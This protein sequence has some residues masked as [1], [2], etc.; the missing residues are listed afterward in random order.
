S[1][2]TTW[3]VDPQFAGASLRVTATGQT[4][5]A[6]AT[7][8]FTDSNVK[9]GMTTTGD[10]NDS[11]TVNWTTYSPSGSIDSGKSGTTALSVGGNANL[12]G[13]PPGSRL[14]ITAPSFSKEGKQF[15]YWI[16]N[17]GSSQTV[18]NKP[19]LIDG[20]GFQGNPTIVAHYGN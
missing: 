1:I 12:G 5:G 4:S 13:G 7:R 10:N 11:A 15:Q 19:T 16:I 17:P 18:V 3:F 8:D 9:A 2:G 6:Q 20:V 14:V